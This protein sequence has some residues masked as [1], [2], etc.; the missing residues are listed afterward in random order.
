MMAL[1]I[2]NFQETRENVD[3]WDSSEDTINEAF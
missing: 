2:L 1:I 3:G